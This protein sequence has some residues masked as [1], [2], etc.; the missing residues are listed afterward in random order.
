MKKYFAHF[1]GLFLLLLVGVACSKDE[2]PDPEPQPG[3]DRSANLLATGDSAEDL[4]TNTDFDNLRIQI[5]YVNGFRPTDEAL[6][7][8]RNF[9][10]QRTF[11]ENITFEFLALPSPDEESLT[12]QEIAVLEN[13]NRT[14]YN[15]GRT[16]AVYIYFADAPADGDDLDGGTFTL[17]AVYRNTSMVIHERTL[18][19]ISARSLL[20]STAD[21]ETATLNHEFGHL[22]GLVDLSTPEVNPHEDPEAANHC[23]IEGCLMQAKLEFGGSAK[24]VLESR[25]SKG[26]AA[27]PVLDAECIRDLQAIGGR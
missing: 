3:I 27:V 24:A 12:L 5:A 15:E 14:L 9:L 20:I 16:L 6:A 26:E 2:S 13:E 18:R 1:A 17:G 22:F 23:D 10:L 21:V 25:A 8:L 7:N 19:S 4:L 11:K